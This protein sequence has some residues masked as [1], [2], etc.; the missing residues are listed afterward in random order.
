MATVS[1]CDD[2]DSWNPGLAYGRVA[3]AAATIGELGLRLAL[4]SQDRNLWGFATL[5][6]WRLSATR[7]GDPCERGS[8]RRRAF[9]D[10]QRA[11]EPGIRRGHREGRFLTVSEPSFDPERGIG[12]IA[13]DRHDRN[14]V[15]TVEP[16]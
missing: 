15:G 14:A 13:I 5:S 6:D 3:T 4:L 10:H 7:A 11:G 8:R 16:P 1:V 2:V 12:E 9:L